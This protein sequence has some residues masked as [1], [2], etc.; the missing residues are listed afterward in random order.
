MVLQFQQEFAKTIYIFVLHS[1]KQQQNKDNGLL[2]TDSGIEEPKDVDYSGLMNIAN[3]I[4][5]W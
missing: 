1:K 4:M 2:T 5:V 3:G